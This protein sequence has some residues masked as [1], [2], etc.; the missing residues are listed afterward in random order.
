MKS[1]DWLPKVAQGPTVQ[2]TALHRCH[3]NKGSLPGTASV[4]GG[5]V[6]ITHLGAM[7]SCKPCLPQP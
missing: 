3:W 2:D 5:Q 7:S 6:H 4:T 1:L